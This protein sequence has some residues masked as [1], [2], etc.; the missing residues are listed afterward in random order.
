MSFASEIRFSE[1]TSA[2]F[3]S[4]NVSASL[5]CSRRFGGLLS[6]AGIGSDRGGRAKLLSIQES[7]VPSGCTDTWRVA[8][9]VNEQSEV[10]GTAGWYDSAAMPDS[11]LYRC[12]L[13]PGMRD[14]HLALKLLAFLDR[15]EEK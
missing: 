13:G 2:Y 9:R 7:S 10:I 15:Q 4:A 3:R 8:R 6:A 5:P 1:E 11:F 14:G 12:L